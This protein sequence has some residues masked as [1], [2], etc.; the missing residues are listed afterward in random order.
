MPLVRTV[1]TVHCATPLVRPMVGH[2]KGED[3]RESKNLDGPYSCVKFQLHQINLTP[4]SIA[5][6][7]QPF[8][9]PQFCAIQPNNL[10]NSDWYKP[11]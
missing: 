4:S 1:L 5:L 3:L 10:V 7:F 6:N 11:V 9:L 8:I 2:R